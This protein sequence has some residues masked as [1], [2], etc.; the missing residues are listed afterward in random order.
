[1]TQPRPRLSARSLAWPLAVLALGVA[2][3][4]TVNVDA[5]RTTSVMAAPTA[6]AVVDVA[7]LVEEIDERGEWDMR[8]EVLQ[9]A[10]N[11]EYKDRHA[12]M[13]RRLKESESTSDEA[14]RQTIRDEVALMQLRLEEWARLKG[15]ELDRERSLKWKSIY[16]N[17]RREAAR[18]AE[19]DGYEL[20]LVND[21]TAVIRTDPAVQVPL[22]QQV[23][24]Q[25]QNRR[26]LFSAPPIDITEQIIV[27]MNNAIPQP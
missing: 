22:E 27:R 5:S 7:R 9:A 3:T 11:D 1:M 17:L 8:I 19:A 26:I 21:S 20:V 14:V 4:Y 12:A 23:L 13:E 10:I 24:T 18:V 16:R 6:I 15:Q 2:W 25:I